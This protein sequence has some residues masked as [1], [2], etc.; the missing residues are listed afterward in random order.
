ML[1]HFLSGESR[2][3]DPLKASTLVDWPEPTTGKEVQKLLGFVN[4]IRDYIPLVSRKGPAKRNE[5]PAKP[6]FLNRYNHIFTW[7]EITT[8]QC[9]QRPYG[10][11]Y[12]GLSIWLHQWSRWG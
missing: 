8:P 10:V 11:V 4:F 5:G 7:H 3:V 9:A 1:G 2:S 12:E 6:S